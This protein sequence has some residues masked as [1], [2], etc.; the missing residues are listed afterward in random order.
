MLRISG[1]GGREG[2]REEGV[3][4]RGPSPDTI[5]VIKSRTVRWVGY[6][7]LIGEKRPLGRP[8]RRWKNNIRTRNKEV[9]W[10]DVDRINKVHDRGQWRTAVCTVM[11]LCVPHKR[12]GIS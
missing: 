7:A 3:I 11:K 2:G 9:M 8:K 1:Q 10:E 6:V 4:E 12:R 5:R